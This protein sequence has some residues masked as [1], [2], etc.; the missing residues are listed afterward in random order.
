[1]RYLAGRIKP[2]AA[3]NDGNEPSEACRLQ[4]AERDCQDGNVLGETMELVAQ[5]DIEDEGG[6]R[7]T[8]DDR[9]NLGIK[10][11]ADG[12]QRD[13]GHPRYHE[14]VVRRYAQMAQC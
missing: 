5:G 12:R 11:A 3:R 6:R 8:P 13:R 14:I 2:Y 9:D 10:T 4:H 1:M 7:E